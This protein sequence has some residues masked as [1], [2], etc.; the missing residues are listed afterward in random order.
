MALDSR[1]NCGEEFAKLSRSRPRG[2][3]FS[4]RALKKRVRFAVALCRFLCGLV[5]CYFH[6][7]RRYYRAA[8]KG[9]EGVCVGL[10][11]YTE[12][13]SWIAAD[14]HKIEKGLSLQEPRPGFGMPVVRRLME[15][16]EV[17]QRTFGKER[18]T[19]VAVNTLLAYC[20]FNR[21]RGLEDAALYEEVLALAGRSGMTDADAMEGGV[22]SVTREAIQAQSCLPN[23]EDFFRSRY[24]IRD[25]SQVP[26]ALSSVEAAVRMALKTPSV[27]NRQSWKVYSFLDERD[28][29][30]VLEC[31]QGNRGFGDLAGGVLIVTSDL[32]TFFSHGERNQAWTD[33]GMFAMSL[34]YALHAQGLGTCCLNWCV[35]L[36]RD[37]NLRKRVCIPDNEVIIMLIAVGHLPEELNVA[38]SPRKPLEEVLVMG[39]LDKPSADRD[40]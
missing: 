15:H 14:T 25:F 31:Q 32:A 35:E 18:M 19:R 29:R 12:L 37:R 21:D 7:F 24:S 33:G 4:L 34:V 26:V 23:I 3:A 17:F 22:L 2:G 16:L 11:R 1:Q 28:T 30:E 5:A 20:R 13:K 6:D 8:S 40:H 39:Q 27:C 9:H 38:Q 10:P 36:R